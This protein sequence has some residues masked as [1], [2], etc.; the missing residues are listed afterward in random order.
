MR[1]YKR[2]RALSSLCFFFVGGVKSG[3]GKA[4][5]K[6]TR[7]KEEGEAGSGAGHGQ[8]DTLDVAVTMH[9]A[10]A[11]ARDG[12]RMPPG[13]LGLGQ[14]IAEARELGLDALREAGAELL[15]VR[16]DVV[17]LLE[18]LG[19]VDLE[20]LVHGGG[21]HVQALGVEGAR[22]GGDADRGRDAVRLA[23]DA[24]DDP[25]EHARVLAEPGPQELVVPNERPGRVRRANEGTTG[26][27]RGNEGT[28]ERGNES[29]GTRERG[30]EGTRE[31]GSEGTRE[32]G[33]EGTRER[34]SEGT[35]ERRRQG[36]K[37]GACASLAMG[38][39]CATSPPQTHR[40]LATNLV[41]LLAEPV[42]VENLGQLVRGAAL[43]HAQ[44]VAKVVRHVVAAER[45]HREGV[46]AVW[47]ATSGR[48]GDIGQPRAQ[49]QN[50]GSELARTRQNP[51]EPARTR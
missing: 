47:V 46:K 5:Y 43:R 19:L 2:E 33:S 18:P 26:R 32:L 14:A 8:R 51:L 1:R 34:G 39:L 23:V 29:E 17:G 27:E 42:D 31:R 41:V 37:E 35:R 28:R 21:A 45:Q 38:A 44:P 4:P 7:D 30:S 15:L 9:A 10:H 40:T 3:E 16:L 48:V 6:Q 22:G 24:V 12:M 50:P 20:Q 36:G 13:G 25:L 11:R 49:G